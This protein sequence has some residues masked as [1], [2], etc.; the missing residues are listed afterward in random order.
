MLSTLFP[1]EAATLKVSDIAS[2]SYATNRPDLAGR[3]WWIQIY[4][5]KTNV[6]DAASWYHARYI[7]NYADHS[8]AG[9]W[10]RYSTRH[11][12][13]AV[14]KMTFRLQASAHWPAGNPI[15]LKAIG[16][17][18][19]EMISVQTDS[20]WNG[21]DGSLD[22][23]E[24]VLKNGRVGR[25]NFVGCAAGDF[26]VGNACAEC[27]PIADCAG[28]LTCTTSTNSACGTCAATFVP[29]G[30]G[31][32]RCP[33]GLY[34]DGS[35]CESCPPVELCTG[36]VTCDSPTT[37]IC[38]DCAEEYGFD[39]VTHTCVDIDWCAAEPEACGENTVCSDGVGA[40]SCACEPG[41]N[42]DAYGFDAYGG[43]IDATMI[44]AAP[45]DI[46]DEQQP[47]VASDAPDGY[48]PDAWRGPVI[49]KSNYYVYVAPDGTGPLATLFPASA[50]LTMSMLGSLSYYTK[51]PA[52]TAA[53]RD[54][55]ITIYTKP[56]GAGDDAASWYHR[57]Y[58][59]NYGDHTAVDAWTRYSTAHATGAVP[60]MNFREYSP[61]GSSGTPFTLPLEPS[62]AFAND[63]ILAISVHTDSGW[64]GF[65]GL[66]D[67]LEIV[68][69][70]DD[71]VGRVNFGS[72]TIVTV[73]PTE[74]PDEREPRTYLHVAP[75]A[76]PPS[77]GPI[78]WQ[79]PAGG[80]T[81]WYAAY[82][83]DDPGPLSQLFPDEAED[84]TIGDLAE[85]SYY[86]RRPAGT[87]ASRDWWIT[88]YTRATGSGDGN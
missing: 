45:S 40:H 32:C 43:C 25:V 71:G 75:D 55:W 58:I 36:A 16:N 42:G 7:N 61:S 80:K 81:N 37:P 47:R 77:Y 18:L 34:D 65:D 1:A 2:I 19:V 50:P 22:G 87:Q 28:N 56:K 59:N 76:A 12:S 11:A 62:A 84:L 44:H 68:L 79:G 20:G 48:G 14:G 78:S 82:T 41:F 13:G 46:P 69:T 8:A 21:F 38:D 17:E 9:A 4:T 88:I 49:G 51:R 15:E 70:D 83:D 23:L 57:R 6:N 39:P 67:G 31:G 53:S 52:G 27:A 85:V 63:E 64:N 26:P 86:T 33:A 10:T 30:V 35:S 60:A 73:G 72:A 29:D 74:V 24:I 66:I 5:R 3:D 54:W